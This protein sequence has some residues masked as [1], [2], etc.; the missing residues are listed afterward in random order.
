[1]GKWLVT[2]FLEVVLRV[3]KRIRLALAG[4]T[5]WLSASLQTKGSLVVFPVYG[6]GLGCRPGPPTGGT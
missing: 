3:K 5:Q 4:V 6:T 1:M 2:E